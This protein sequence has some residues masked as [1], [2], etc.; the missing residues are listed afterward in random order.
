MQAVDDKIETIHLYVVREQAKQPFTILP[1]V[2][3]LLCIAA[4]IGVTYYSAL[5]PVYEHETLTIPAHGLPPQTFTASALV[6]PTGVKT[7]P[8]TYAHGLLMFSN[9]SVIG[10][11]IPQGFTV[12]GAATDSALYVPPATA[13]GL[14][15][16][17]VPAHLLASGINIPTLSINEV[18]GS[19]LFVR[20][21]EPFTGGHPAY[22][23]KYV[24][25]Q[26]KQT[27]FTQAVDQ[28][29]AMVTGLH[30]PCVEDHFASTNKMT[31]T[32]RC[33]F[34]TYRLP[35]YMHVSNAHLI[36][37]NL[38]LVV[39]FIPHPVHIWVK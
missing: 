32:W 26:D 13:D 29:A 18:I 17:T 20:N 6:A 10:L 23:V 27:A 22:S 39:W 1:I 38:I 4:L 24:T 14:G 8:A 34:V 31:I 2:A 3:A 15:M 12:D 35:S 30:Y 36:G 11:S 21:L 33:Q 28:L 25:E 37:K 9:G 16:S 19:S 7:Y 5:H